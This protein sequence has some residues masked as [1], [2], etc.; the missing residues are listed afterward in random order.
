MRLVSLTDLLPR[1]LYAAHAAKVAKE[2]LTLECDYEYERRSQ[3]KMR[4]LLSDDPHWRVPR[5]V[6]ELSS[7]NASATVLIDGFFFGSK[8][9]G[10]VNRGS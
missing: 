3:E 6:P 8:C 7:A 4:R 9:S 10:I 5:T 2:E 1:G